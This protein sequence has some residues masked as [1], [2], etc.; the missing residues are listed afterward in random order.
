MVLMVLSAVGC[1]WYTAHS[2]RFKT[3]RADLIDPSAAFHQRWLKFTE[4][5]GERNDI[6]VAIEADSPELI[7]QVQDEIGTRL[8]QHPELFTNVLYR[9]EPGKLRE[10][11]LQYLTPEQLAVG[12]D[13]LKEYQPVLDGHWDLVSL[14]TL[15]PRLRAQLQ[16]AEQKH[17]EQVPIVLD[18]IDRLTSSAYWVW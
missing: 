4:S 9:I 2:L 7:K 1:V 5:F 15:V 3:N 14:Q 11:G 12:L 17:P 8:Q 10:K 18:H 13:R 6:A 16:N